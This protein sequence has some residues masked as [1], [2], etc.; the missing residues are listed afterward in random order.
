MNGIKTE[1]PLFT[2]LAKRKKFVTL[3]QFMQKAKQFINQEEVVGALMKSKADIHLARSNSS[4]AVP[5]SSIKKGRKRRYLLKAYKRKGTTM[6]AGPKKLTSLN[7]SVTEVFMEI[8][9]DPI[10]IGPQR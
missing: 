2:E 7:T 5:Q 9:G 4:K 3:P 1:G 6:P 10:L 8:K